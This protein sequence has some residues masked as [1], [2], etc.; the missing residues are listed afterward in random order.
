MPSVGRPRSARSAKARSRP[1]D[2]RSPRSSTVALVPGST[3]RS[4]SI[5]SSRDS[6]KRTDTPGSW[7]RASKSVKLLMRPS[8]ATATR[9][10]SRP[11]G[12]FV[13]RGASRASEAHVG[14]VVLSEVDL[15]RAPGPLADHHVEPRAQVLQGIQDY[16]EEFLLH[17]PVAPSARRGP[18]L[19]PQD[20]LGGPFGRRFQEDGVH[21]RLGFDHRGGGLGGLGAPDLGPLPRHEGVERHVLRLERRY[22]DPLPR[23]PPADASDDH[24]LA[25][26]GVGAG[27]EQRTPQA[28]SPLRLARSHRSPKSAP[29]PAQKTSCVPKDERRK[30]HSN[31][32]G[33]PSADAPGGS[34][35]NSTATTASNPTP[36]TARRFRSSTPLSRMR[37]AASHA[38]ST[39]SRERAT[40]VKYAAVRAPIVEGSPTEGGFA[41][42]LRKGIANVPAK[43]AAVR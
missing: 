21:R 41:G 43:R 4:A 32:A 1:R 13:G 12:G 17:P 22:L 36:T 8:L 31:P 18:R 5:S 11:S 6:V 20:D 3:A 25:G 9:T 33:N 16:G 14:Q 23:Q 29:S 15:R 26:V 39:A 27:D 37:R 24:A 40:S 34:A 2:R 7:P 42:Y 30:P 19:A 10:T 35:R 28:V 38:A